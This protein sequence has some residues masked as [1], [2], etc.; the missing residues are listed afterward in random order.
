MFD[1]I[2]RLFKT[3]PDSHYVVV[4]HHFDTEC[5]EYIESLGVKSARQFLQTHLFYINEDQALLL[6]L[7]FQWIKIHKR[8]EFE[9]D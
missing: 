1:F 7:K 5:I 4:S 8:E 6:K 3:Q 2:K 9:K